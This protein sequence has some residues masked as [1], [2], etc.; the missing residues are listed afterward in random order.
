MKTTLMMLIIWDCYV[1]NN[2]KQEWIEFS[3]PGIV[4]SQTKLA[5]EIVNPLKIQTYMAT[6][7]A[8]VA[9]LV[10]EITIQFSLGLSDANMI[11]EANQTQ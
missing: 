10:N 3:Q 4:L 6:Y 8:N 2:L 11:L 7:I 1:Q 5:Q 9:L